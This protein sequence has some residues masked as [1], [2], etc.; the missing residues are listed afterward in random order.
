MAKITSVCR[1]ADIDTSKLSLSSI[2]TQDN[3]SKMMYIQHKGDPIFIQLPV[4]QSPYG[5]SVWPT[6][7]K[8]TAAEKMNLDLSLTGYDSNPIMKD[9]FNVLNNIEEYV[10]QN[11]LDQSTA[12]FKK[13]YTT[14]VVYEQLKLNEIIT[15][16]HYLQVLQFCYQLQSLQQLLGICYQS[17]MQPH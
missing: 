14:K 10:M 11:A 5:I 4:M 12:W 15:F 2:K 17:V 8:G 7:A 9:T 6:D 16:Y 3:G 1:V 13:K